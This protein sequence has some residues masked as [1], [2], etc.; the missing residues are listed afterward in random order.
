MGASM[1]DASLFSRQFSELI[2][3]IRSSLVL[4]QAKRFG[5]G[6]GFIWDA[7]GLVITN[8]HVL[9]RGNSAKIILSDDRRQDA[10]VVSRDLEIDLALLRLPDRSLPAARI[11]D[12]TQLKVGHLV[13]ALGHPWGS[14]NAAS[15]GVISHLGTAE[16]QGSRGLIPIIRIDAHLAP[17][18]S[19]GPLLNAS[20]E[21]IG[22]N[23][24]VVGGDQGVAVPSAVAADFVSQVVARKQPHVKVS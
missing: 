1:M 21:V 4:V 13:F 7:E 10:R 17:G 23:T 9:G 24:M 15:A 12:S 22:I 16:T 8:N 2:A 3:E 5:A 11:G 6:A 14:R 19:G 20:G 18:N